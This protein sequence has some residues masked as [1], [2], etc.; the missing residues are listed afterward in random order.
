MSIL[1]R[2]A[3]V[4]LATTAVVAVTSTAQAQ[5]FKGV[6][7]GDIVVR[8]RALA[9][10]PQEKGDVTADGLGSIGSADIKNDYIPEVDVTYF[11]TP[12]IGL[13][14]IAGTSRHSVG[15]DLNPGASA[16]LGT[17]RVDAG[18]VSLLPPTLTA[19]YH[20][21]PDSRIN[22]YIGAGIN[23]TLFYNVKNGPTLSGT[24]YDNAFGWALQ[25]GV[26]V[27]LTDNWLLNFD[28]KKIWLDT[29]LKTFLDTTQVS[30]KVDINPWIVGVGVG[31]KF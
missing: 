30:S 4:L 23:W 12:N 25:A 26:D 1:K 3:A 5:D 29:K 19:T 17:S 31:Y 8:A 20:P 10:L 22:P 14:L 28:V 21:L 13:N 9:V 27:Y 6:K 2:A 16:L 15:V 11:V 24:S 7:G 18:K